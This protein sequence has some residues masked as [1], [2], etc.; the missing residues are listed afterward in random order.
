MIILEEYNGGG[1]HEEKSLQPLLAALNRYCLS[2]TGSPWD[3]EDLAQDTLVKAMAA[4]KLADNPNPEAL[5]LRI[6]KNTWIDK[7]RRSNVFRRILE[8]MRTADEPQP[9]PEPGSTGLQIIFQALIKHLSPLQRTVFLLRDVLGY[10]AMEAAEMLESTEGAVKSSLYR[11]RQ[12]LQAVRRELA[13]DGPALPLEEGFRN[14]LRAL[15]L[16][17]EDGQTAAL[18]ELANQET[19]YETVAIGSSMPGM[20]Q[21]GGFF[22]GRGSG[23]PEMRM[24]A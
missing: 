15:A 23:Q 22:A 20:Q 6:A 17:Y 1:V 10:S 11:A 18:L 4:L 8:S 7:S 12:A 3:A 9:E 16:A 5:L 14:Y 24:A 2:L 13:A 19:A 21:A